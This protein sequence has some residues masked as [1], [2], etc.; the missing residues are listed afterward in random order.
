MCN[1][2]AGGV[3]LKNASYSYD[4]NGNITIGDGRTVTWSTF[5][6]PLAIS[7]GSNSSTMTYGPERQLLTR[8]DVAAGQTTTSVHVGGG[9]YDKVTLPSGAVEE[10]HTLGPNTVVTY[11]NRTAGSAGT[12]KTRYLHK[13]H[14]GS[15]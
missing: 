7:Q 9:A 11:T 13:D 15:I 8:S 3:G 14:L 6:K 12:L 1:I 4:A 2:S 5:D 10:R